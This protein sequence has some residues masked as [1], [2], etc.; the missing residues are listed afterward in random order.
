MTVARSEMKT[1]W[2]LVFIFMSVW[3]YFW[4]VIERE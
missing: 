3:F 4:N 2:E 1:L